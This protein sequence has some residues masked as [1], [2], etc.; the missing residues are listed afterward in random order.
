MQ[1]ILPIYAIFCL[2]ALLGLQIGKW[3]ARTSLSLA[4]WGAMGVVIYAAA[5][6]D[7]TG[8]TGRYYFAFEKMAQQS[9]SDVL[10]E[11]DSNWLFNYLNWVLSRFGS[12]PLVLILPTTLFCVYMLR[13]SLMKVVSKSD[14]TIAILLY[15]AYPFFVFYLSSGIKQGIAMAC[16]MEGY[17]LWHRQ[18]KW[19]ALTWLALAP[20]FHSGSV[21]VFPMLLIHYALWRPYIGGHRA[22]IFSM[23]LLIL[24][25][26]LSLSG[27]NQALMAPVQG[28][29]SFNSNYDVYFMD[30]SD[31]GYRAGFR[32]D[33]TL[34]T[35][36]PWL[37]ALWL[38]KKGTGL[39]MA[40]SG[41]WLNLYTLLAC[42]YQLFAFAPFA[43]RFA[44][45]G[46][47]LMP[48][49][50]VIMLADAGALKPRQ[51]IVLLFSILN[52]AI[53]YLYTGANSNLVR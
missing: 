36:L 48:A 31:I 15:S 37:A 6:R 2:W 52:V 9:F 28:Y 21:L 32:V 13:N 51:A 1:S 35:F 16:L 14:A 34:F 50:L 29:A 20:L 46:W 10:N 44:S 24:C 40:V 30:A 42:I 5:F 7:I 53:M 43:D 23:S 18:K 4:A 45:F 41:W 25:T 8:D 38:R 33:F 47:Y 26:I 22:L 49:I 3:E 19:P 39:T 11:T 17:V 12:D 27:F